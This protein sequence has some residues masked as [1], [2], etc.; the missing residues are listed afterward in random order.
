MLSNLILLKLAEA[1]TSLPYTIANGDTLGAIAKRHNVALNDLTR[2]NNISNPN[3]IR[4]GQTIKIPQIAS[5]AAPA[6]QPKPAPAVP[7]PSAPVPNNTNDITPSIDMDYMRD[8]TWYYENAAKK[9][10]DP[11]TGQWTSYIDRGEKDTKDYQAI[12]PGLRNGGTTPF[13]M[14]D[15]QVRQFHQ[16]KLMEIY[17]RTRREYPQFD[18][19]APHQKKI[20][21]DYMY[22]GVKAPNFYDYSLAGNVE[23][24]LKEIGLKNNAR[25]TQG[26]RDDLFKY[27]PGQ[28]F[29]NR[30]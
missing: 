8:Y 24:Q 11:K 9:G 29:N 27:T 23:G 15:E 6:I 20:L 18:S 30:R 25:R 21:F 22:M 12:G 16:Q 19:L 28:K 26:M 10:Y 4:A 3:R 7:L 5:P 14:S 13:T 2:Y 17:Q 1:S